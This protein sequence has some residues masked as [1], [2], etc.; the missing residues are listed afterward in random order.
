MKWTFQQ[1]LDG[2]LELELFLRTLGLETETGR[3][4]G[5]IQTIRFLED[6]RIRGNVDEIDI[7]QSLDSMT[8][9]IEL[10]EVYRALKAYDRTV[11]ARKFRDVLQ[12][13]SQPRAED[14]N[15]NHGRNTAFELSMAARFHKR[16]VFRA[17]RDN[18]DVLCEV[19]G[20]PVFVQC[21]R[22][23]HER[24][25][26][27]N[28]AKAREQLRRDLAGKYYP[29]SCAIVAISLSRIIGPRS[30]LL[31]GIDSA[32]VRDETRRRI[33]DI[34]QSY[35]TVC[36]KE[37]G[38]IATVFHVMMPVFPV[39]AERPSGRLGSVDVQVT[40]L[41]NPSCEGQVTLLHQ[42]FAKPTQ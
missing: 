36:R 14:S 10:V 40:Y 30:L 8:E 9:A 17:L 39:D 1:V 3:L 41:H 28:I 18:P 24:T 4:G 11:L 19:L 34:A 12:G 22:P 21:K 27:R 37:P 13:P 23:L 25:I 33:D 32:G 42:L 35:A 2:L 38:I 15:T 7:E 20:I 29:E 26:K 5:H 31:A 6:S 16:G